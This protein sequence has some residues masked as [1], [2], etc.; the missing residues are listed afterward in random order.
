MVYSK[1]KYSFLV[2]VILIGTVSFS[3]GQTLGE[4]FN[5]KK[6]QKRYLL[7]QIAAL[8]VYIGYAKKGYEIAG[9]GLQTIRD[10]SNGEFSLHNAFISSLKQVSPAIR[11]N[12]KIAEI[13]ALQIAIGKAFGAVKNNDM[14]SPSARLYIGQVKDNVME[15]SAKDLEELLLIITSGKLEMGDQERLQRLD[16][17]YI[18]MKDKSAFTQDFCNNV[19]LLIRQKATELESINQL[20]K[21]YEVH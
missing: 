19:K 6:T 8:E 14:L 5:Q 13:I 9:S 4:F 18:S 7:E 17:V 2:L 10:I 12:A 16:K 3:Y 20:K 21:S 11:S 1:I 15:E